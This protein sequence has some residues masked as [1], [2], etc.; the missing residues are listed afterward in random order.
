MSIIPVLALFGIA[1]FFLRTGGW[2]GVFMVLVAAISV[3]EALSYF[4]GKTDAFIGIMV[5]SSAFVGGSL[6][7][8]LCKVFLR[9][10]KD[11]R[12][13]SL[14]KEEPLDEYLSDSAEHVLRQQYSWEDRARNLPNIPGDPNINTRWPNVE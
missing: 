14:T 1:A 2:R 7:G 3:I 4:D 8:L 6:T 11:Q 10:S 12:R 13:F 5:V 9:H